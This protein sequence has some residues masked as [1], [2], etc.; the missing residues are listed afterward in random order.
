M[1]VCM[2]IAQSGYQE[3]EYGIPQGIF[4][5]A[6]IEVVVA[7]K[8]KGSATGHMGNT[9][10]VDLAFNQVDVSEFDA[11]VFIGGPGATTYVEDIEAH[12]IARD[13]IEEKKVLAAICIAPLILAHAGVLK[14]IHATV[15]NKDGK[16][17]A[18]LKAVGAKYVDESVVTDGKIITANGPMSA[19]AFGKRIVEV[20][21]Q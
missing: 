10:K 9:T 3:R 12:M 21:K 1:K 6:E 19:E 7:A 17:A 14:D 16:P 8:E 4:K 5:E 15:W 13:A 2:I 20:L 11:I 18:R